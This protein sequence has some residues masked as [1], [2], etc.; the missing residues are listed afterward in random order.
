[1]YILYAT[2]TVRYDTY[3]SFVVVLDCE[4]RVPNESLRRGRR[5]DAT[6][7]STFYFLIGMLGFVFQGAVV[8]ESLLAYKVYKNLCAGTAAHTGYRFSYT[9]EESKLVLY[10]LLH[11]AAHSKA[12]E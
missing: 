7:F 5:A 11:S 9:V 2:P 8:S 4:R 6:V 1:M 10:T 3:R 12:I